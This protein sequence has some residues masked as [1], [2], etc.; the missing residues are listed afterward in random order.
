MPQPAAREQN[1]AVPSGRATAHAVATGTLL[2]RPSR[3][4]P[5]PSRRTRGRSGRGWAA[6]RTSLSSASSS[7]SVDTSHSARARSSPFRR[8]AGL[9]GELR[10][11]EHQ[12]AAT[13]SPSM[14]RRPRSATRPATAAGHRAAVDSRTTALRSSDPPP[15]SIA[16][17]LRRARARA[18][19]TPTELAGLAGCSLTSLANIE[20]GAGPVRSAVLTRV[21]ATLARLDEERAERVS[22]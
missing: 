6:T 4:R 13:D 16:D 18:E 21:R 3:G 1:A 9:A 2:P 10:D 12:R 22:R 15:G 17:E 5:P 19:V 14:P 11:R 7:P 20:Q 8:D